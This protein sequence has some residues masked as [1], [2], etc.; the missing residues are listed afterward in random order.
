MASLD[1]ASSRST[2]IEKRP[3]YLTTLFALNLIVGL[4]PPL[5]YPSDLYGVNTSKLNL[6]VYSLEPVA[7]SGDGLALCTPQSDTSWTGLLRL[8]L[9]FIVNM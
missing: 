6:D 8:C 1:L 3:G 5:Q 7:Y 4:V 9:I 2:G